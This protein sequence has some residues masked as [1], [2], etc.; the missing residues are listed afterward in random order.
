MMADSDTQGTQDTQN[1]QD[2]QARLRDVLARILDLTINQRTSV[3]VDSPPG[4]GKTELIVSVVWV[5]A[6]RHGLRTAIVAPRVSQVYDL[7]RRLGAVGP[8]LRIQV[9]LASD[10]A[11]PADLASTPGMLE[12]VSRARDIDP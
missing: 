6:L 7:C 12:P 9:L 2:I 4:A 3:I 5:L 11:L 10:R 8:A 1:S